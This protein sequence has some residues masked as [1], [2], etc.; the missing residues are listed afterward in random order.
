MFLVNTAFHEW[1]GGGGGGKVRV[2]EVIGMVYH[3][4]SPSL[5]RFLLIIMIFVMVAKY[6]RSRLNLL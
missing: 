5:L 4:I 1:R 2:C 3:I 6:S